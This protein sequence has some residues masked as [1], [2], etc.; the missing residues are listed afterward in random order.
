MTIPNADPAIAH[1]LHAEPRAISRSELFLGFLKCGLL[2]FGGC[3]PIVR[4]VIVEE[5]G[6]LSERDYAA[7]IGVGQ[8]LPGANTVN[9]AVMIGDKFQGIVG[10]LLC[11]AGLLAAPLAIL[12][13]VASLYA[14]FAGNR[15]VEAGMTGAAAAGAGLVIGTAAK[16]LQGLKLSPI[17]LA[18]CAA[19]FGAVVI[20]GWPMLPVLVVL[21]PASIVAAAFARGR[22]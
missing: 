13:G 16:M 7:V 9:A 20:L 15:F 11:L 6:W 19:A 10:S 3:G 14:S 4:H 22:A 8:A 1:A 18:F 2:G 21:I 5:K 12:I 17:A